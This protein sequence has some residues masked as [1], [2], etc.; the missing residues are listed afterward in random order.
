MLPRLYTGNEVKQKNI[1]IVGQV[2]DDVIDESRNS[3]MF[4]F[5]LYILFHKISKHGVNIF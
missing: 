4:V 1:T 5:C 3:E 2:R